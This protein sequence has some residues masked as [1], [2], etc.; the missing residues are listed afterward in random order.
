MEN[1]KPTN[2]QKPNEPKPD[3]TKPDGTK[4]KN[5]I[6]R[7]Q[8]GTGQKIEG[9]HDQFRIPNSDGTIS[10]FKNKQDLDDYIQHLRDQ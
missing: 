5:T 6:T 9:T 2:E 4:S 1:F 10:S 3:G 8:E 7:K